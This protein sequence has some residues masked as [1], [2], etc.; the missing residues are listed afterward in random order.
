M[1]FKS[2]EE[3]GNGGRECPFMWCVAK[4]ISL[5]PCFTPHKKKRLP[6]IT[7]KQLESRNGSKPQCGQLKTINSALDWFQVQR[8]TTL[9]ITNI[10]G[11][12]FNVTSHQQCPWLWVLCFHCRGGYIGIAQCRITVVLPALQ[13]RQQWDRAAWETS[14]LS[15]LPIKAECL[16]GKVVLQLDHWTSRTELLL[17]FT[18]RC[19][20]E[21]H[22]KSASFCSVLGTGAIPCFR[23]EKVLYC[24]LIVNKMFLRI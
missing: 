4:N 7:T 9:L 14:S 3:G 20:F 12:H 1:W 15:Q 17:T 2:I 10:L 24:G 18:F 6:H 19:D 11:I 8:S 21:S 5:C 22:L 23:R 13:S 16:E